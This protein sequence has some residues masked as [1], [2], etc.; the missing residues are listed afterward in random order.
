MTVAAEISV[1]DT[2]ISV[3]PTGKR[4]PLWYRMAR[5]LAW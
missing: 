2:S 5:L 1:S 4:E 3:K